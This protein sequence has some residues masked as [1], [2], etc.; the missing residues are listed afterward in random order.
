MAY[1]FSLAARIDD[2]AGICGDV[3][4]TKAPQRIFKYESAFAA[5]SDIGEGS[6][7]LFDC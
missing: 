1:Q 7:C 3:I 2:V 5:G 6:A 4:I